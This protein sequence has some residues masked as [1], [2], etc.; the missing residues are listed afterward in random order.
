ME[1]NTMRNIVFADS[2]HLSPAAEERIA[3]IGT[4]FRCSLDERERLLAAAPGADLIVAEYARIDEELLARC[5]KL[6]GIIVYG[7]GVNHIDLEA[8]SKRG[9]PVANSRG[10]NAEAVAELALSLMLECLRRTG[11]A[12]SFITSGQWNA[13]DSA[14]LPSWMQGRELKGKTLGI[15]GPGAIGGRVG[16]LGE[17][18]GMRVVVYGGNTYSGAWSRL[19]LDDL[20]SAADIVS[21]NL[22]LVESTAGLL[23]REKLQRMKN[24]SLLV[25]TSRG[26]IVDEAALAMLLSAGHIAGAGLD[27]FAEEPLPASSP[28]LSAPNIV[29]TPHMGGSTEEAV[30]NISNIIAECC[31]ALLA[32]RLPETT[33]NKKLLTT[34]DR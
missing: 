34:G 13:G 4:I 3:S 6:R 27:V 8:A 15:L 20:L 12:N 21:V 17:A 32:G 2:F 9:V 29:L 11:R 26:G 1:V 16:V 5:E 24:G 25:V 28:L 30:I 18:F 33:V 14:A 31:A 10:G 22:P 7:I 19:S 23:S